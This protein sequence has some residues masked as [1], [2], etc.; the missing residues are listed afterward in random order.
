MKRTLFWLAV[1]MALS[2]IIQQSDDRQTNMMGANGKQAP[3]APAKKETGT[4][5]QITFPAK[6][7][8]PRN[9][10]VLF[11]EGHLELAR[12]MLLAT[13]SDK[14]DAVVITIKTSHKKY[15]CFFE[16]VDQEGLWTEGFKLTFTYYPDHPAREKVAN[17]FLIRNHEG[18][19]TA[20]F[21]CRPLPGDVANVNVRCKFH[22]EF[23]DF[24]FVITY[25]GLEFKHFGQAAGIGK[26]IDVVTP[27]KLPKWED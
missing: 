10:R 5:V 3:S 13:H 2:L 23:T 18:K 24:N 6:Q 9:E 25:T 22:D 26:S 7:G 4:K 16:D 17:M 14:V 19:I 12:T 11:M 21:P 8:K 15:S 20:R 27:Q 1:I